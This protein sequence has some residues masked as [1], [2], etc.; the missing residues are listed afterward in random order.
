MIDISNI[1][2]NRCEKQINPDISLCGKLEAFIGGYFLS[3]ILGPMIETLYYD[4]AARDNIYDE[5]DT[6]EKNIVAY[7][8]NDESIAFVN[9]I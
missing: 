2:T 9:V 1:I 5:V 3:T 8:I 4:P 7:F 6:V